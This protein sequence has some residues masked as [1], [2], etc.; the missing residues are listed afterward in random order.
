MILNFMDSIHSPTSSSSVFQ[1]FVQVFSAFEMKINKHFLISKDHIWF[2]G[3]S[4]KSTHSYPY[5]PLSSR[6]HR[7]SWFLADIA[8]YNTP[9]LGL[10]P[11][12]AS[13]LKMMFFCT[14]RCRHSEPTQI[15]RPIISN[16]FWN[17]I[18]ID[19]VDDLSRIAAT[20]AV[21]YFFLLP[22]WLSLHFF[23]FFFCAFVRNAFP[24][25]RQLQI[26]K[27]FSAVAFST[28]L[29]LRVYVL[30]NYNVPRG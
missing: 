14:F 23:S 18:K 2:S 13:E 24:L 11:Q 29:C 10:R 8:E 22:L 20:V 28:R 1:V 12:V 16:A 30:F 27:L 21:V 19:F 6:C 4:H 7:I 3:S 25:T 26:Y 17:F 9:Q 5:R 15:N